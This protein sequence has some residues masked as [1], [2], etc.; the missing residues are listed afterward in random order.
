[1][2]K[3]KMLKEELKEFQKRMDEL[4]REKDEEIYELQMKEKDEEIYDLQNRVTG[5]E[6]RLDYLEERDTE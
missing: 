2:M 6:S 3:K 5:L 4:F 1:M